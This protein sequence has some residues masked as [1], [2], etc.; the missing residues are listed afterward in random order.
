MPAVPWEKLGMSR[1]K[2]RVH[3]PFQ[4]AVLR[5]AE[6]D[7]PGPGLGG[8]IEPSA[9]S[10]LMKS[11][12]QE[13][14]R[15]GAAADDVRCRAPLDPAPGRPGARLDPTQGVQ[16]A[17]PVF[18]VSRSPVGFIER[19]RDA[20]AALIESAPFDR[21]R[22]CQKEIGPGPS[23]PKIVLFPGRVIR[24]EEEENDARRAAVE[25]Q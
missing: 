13:E 22:P 21:G 24:I 5:Q 8:Q 17:L 14:A 12:D 25:V 4:A 15:S 11:I 20:G 2:L 1:G 7:E 3:G 9:I 18:L 6:L 10:G 23:L 16:K 19:E